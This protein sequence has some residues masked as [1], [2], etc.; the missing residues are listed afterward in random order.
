MKSFK[1][2]I[3][4]NKNGRGC[5]IIDTIK[6]CS[7]C[8]KEKP[9]GCYNNCYANNIS[10]RYG[11]DFSNIVK[12]DFEYDDEQLYFFGFHDNK[13]ENEII[14]KML[15]INMP[16]IRIGEMGDPSED[17]EHTIGVCEII[18]QAKIPI[19]IITKHWKTIPDHLLNNI[20]ELGLCINTSVSALDTSIEL[21]YKLYQ[22]NRIKDY[23][24]SVLR[25]VSCDFNMD[26]HEGYIRSQIQN[27]LF[28]N[29]KTI[30][31]VFRPARDNPLVTNKVINTKKKRFLKSESIVS[32]F[33]DKAYLGYCNTC[34]DMCGIKFQ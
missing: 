5:Y 19:V 32:M 13:H 2:K 27:E 26:N 29:V 4:L 25:I 15:K 3:T 30:D 16:F 9:N 7:A 8:S 21:E 18:S 14:K 11:F 10:L 17:W 23:C 28:K 31:T 20:E 24:N 22:F 33:N 6:V 1:G 12:R 34:P